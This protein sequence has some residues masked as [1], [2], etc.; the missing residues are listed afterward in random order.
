MKL[1]CYSILEWATAM[2][3]VFICL[4]SVY[5]KEPELYEHCC[6]CVAFRLSMKPRNSAEQHVAFDVILML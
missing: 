2:A 1:K 4:L 5:C 3:W 6:N